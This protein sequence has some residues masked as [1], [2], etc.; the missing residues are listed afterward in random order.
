MQKSFAK[1]K[2]FDEAGIPEEPILLQ[3]RLLVC[4]LVLKE[5]IIQKTLV[6]VNRCKVW[7]LKVE[8]VRKRFVE[9]VEKRAADRSM[10]DVEGVWNGLKS[11][12]LEVSDNVCGKS[13]GRPRHKV[14]WCGMRNCQRRWMRRESRLKCG[15]PRKL[16]KLRRNTSQRKS[17]T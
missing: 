13:K 8:A 9:Q 2:T 4:D 10:Q 12:L 16:D 3:H 7:R 17:G 5:R 15:G 11:C 6:F 14:T 1:K